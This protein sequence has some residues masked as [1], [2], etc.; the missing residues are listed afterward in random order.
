M[1]VTEGGN[2]FKPGFASVDLDCLQG[3]RG[4]AHGIADRNS[5][6]FGPDV[7]A[8]DPQRRL[9]GSC[10]AVALGLPH[11]EVVLYTQALF[12]RLT[13]PVWSLQPTP[14]YPTSIEARRVGFVWRR[15]MHPKFMRCL[16]TLLPLAFLAACGLGGGGN[17]APAEVN[18][19]E[20]CPCDCKETKGDS[21]DAVA[22]TATDDDVAMDELP[23]TKTA[24]EP[25]PVVL[26][27]NIKV[28]EGRLND[29]EARRRVSNTRISLRECYAP[30][31]KGDATA[32]GEMDVQFTVSGGTGKIIAAIVRESTIKNKDLESC[33]TN[34]VK[35]LRFDPEK[36]SKESIVRFSLVMVGV[37]F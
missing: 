33:V 12:V 1:F 4:P 31:L 11:R 22:A 25:Y 26:V 8:Q 15:G 35:G 28:T 7:Q 30:V 5:N 21:T 27:G 2:P 13:A 19:S 32:R 36:R 29:K 18:C 6:T 20:Q 34:K 23:A 37:K 10:I 17:S 9:L 3:L 24:D 16:I 14:P